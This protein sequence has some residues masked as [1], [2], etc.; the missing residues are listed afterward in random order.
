MN[1]SRLLLIVASILSFDVSVFQAAISFSVKWNAAFD[2]DDELVSNPPL[3]LATGI[4]MATVFAICGLYGLSGAGVIM[5]LPLLRFGLLGIGIA[6]TV[7]GFAFVSLL[8]VLMHVFPAPHTI[9][10]HHLS[11]SFVAL[12]TGL[13]YL[14][15]LAI[16]W[17]RLSARA[18]GGL[19]GKSAM[20]ADLAHGS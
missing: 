19:Y 14:G 12:L 7:E 3:L 18:S 4:L 20:R 5:R 1:K 8:L 13:L 11:A 2:A 17:K 16:G 6:F 9:Y 10:L 15:G